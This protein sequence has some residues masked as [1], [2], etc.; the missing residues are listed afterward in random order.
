MKVTTTFRL[1][2]DEVTPQSVNA[3]RWLADE[4][5]PGE[6]L[7]SAIDV[8]LKIVNQHKRDGK[9]TSLQFTITEV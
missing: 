4:R 5:G 2:P 3:F 9:R 6:E 1:T 7:T 8:L